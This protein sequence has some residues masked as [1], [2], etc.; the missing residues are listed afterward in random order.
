VTDRA[1]LASG[2]I[3]GSVTRPCP[4]PRKGDALEPALVATIGLIVLLGGTVAV[5]SRQG[6]LPWSAP[7]LRTFGGGTS[8]TE[9]ELESASGRNS[10][11]DLMIESTLT[12]PTATVPSPAM[13]VRSSRLAADG[14]GLSETA[15]LDLIPNPVETLAARL[16]RFEERLDQIARAVDRHAA[17]IRQELW[18]AQSDR[19]QQVE[20]DD[21]RRDVALER[22]RADLLATI[23]R[24]AAD[25]SSRP[26]SR[27]PDVSADL[28]ARLARLEAALA[29]VTNPILLPGEVYSP[30]AEFLPE[31]L[32]WEN[33][34]EVGERAFSLADAY[35][36]QRLHLSD[37]T[38]GEIEVFVTTL[39]AL[40]TRSVYPNLQPEPDAAQQTALRSALEEIAGEFPKVR[41]RL[42]REYRE[43]LSI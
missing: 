3:V 21:A 38:R 30:P 10:G 28:Y 36:S 27:R 39:R 20:V 24:A 4:H 17:E 34:N 6:I 40:L 31:A 14:P 2:G 43:G 5:L 13:D 33:W 16:D 25:G 19:A 12:G 37:E 7:S 8:G 1:C 29:A 32:V 18:R 35:S 22:M 11:S 26:G 41:Q 15:R 23:T 42:E 9:A